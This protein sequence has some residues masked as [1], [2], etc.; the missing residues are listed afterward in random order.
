MIFFLS[1][2]GI[3]SNMIVKQTK[4]ER[5]FVFVRNSTEF[6]RFFCVRVQNSVENDDFLDSDYYSAILRLCVD[7][8]TLKRRVL[9]AVSSFFFALAK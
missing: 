9:I 3:N 7:F 5:F 1:A 8:V 4:L 2:V 6:Q